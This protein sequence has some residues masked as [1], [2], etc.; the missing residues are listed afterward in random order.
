MIFFI[1]TFVLHVAKMFSMLARR[2][3]RKKCFILSSF[4]RIIFVKIK[5]ILRYPAPVVAII[6]I[7][8]GFIHHHIPVWD[9]EGAIFDEIDIIVWMI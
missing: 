5:H 2:C 3:S 1:T 7:V 6:G 8:V 9:L 4:P